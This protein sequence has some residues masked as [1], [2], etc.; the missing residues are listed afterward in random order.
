MRVSAVAAL[1]PSAAAKVVLEV[2]V[3]HGLLDHVPGVLHE[4]AAAAVLDSRGGERVRALRALLGDDAG[5]HLLLARAAGQAFGV[6]VAHV[7]CG[8]WSC[9]R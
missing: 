3:V 6:G 1:R 9:L 8:W 4:A 2:V 5:D 7:G